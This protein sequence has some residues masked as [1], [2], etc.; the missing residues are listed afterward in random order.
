[1]RKL[2]EVSIAR[3]T[4]DP[5]QVQNLSVWV[6]LKWYDQLSVAT[7]QVHPS[8]RVVDPVQSDQFARLHKYR[9]KKDLSQTKYIKNHIH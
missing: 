7:Y 1:M 2:N 4:W 9:F 5:C 3:D 6:L 8:I